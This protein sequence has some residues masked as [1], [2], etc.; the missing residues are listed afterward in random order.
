LEGEVWFGEESTNRVIKWRACNKNLVPLSSTVLDLGCGNGQAAIALSAEG[1]QDVTG[2]DYCQAAV[3]L[4]SKIAKQRDA[5]NVRFKKCDILSSVSEIRQCLSRNSFDVCLDK[6]TYDA[7]SLCPENAKSKRQKYI[8]NIFELLGSGGNTKRF[9]IL[10]SCNWTEEELVKQFEERKFNC[11][12]STCYI[13][14]SITLLYTVYLTLNLIMLSVS[15][16]FQALSF[17]QLFQ[18]LSSSSVV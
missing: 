15:Y 8:E 7:I 5:Q 10:T 3:N 18:H 4:A 6:G 17:T 14:T 16:F 13:T 1:F 9:L 2:V 12:N 11:W